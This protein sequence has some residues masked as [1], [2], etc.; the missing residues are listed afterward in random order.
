MGEEGRGEEGI[1]GDLDR[2]ATLRILKSIRAGLIPRGISFSEFIRRAWEI[3]EPN[4]PITWG[5][6]ID[7]LAELLTA[8][9]LGQIKD[10][11]I[12]IPP[13]WMKSTIVSV[14]FPCWEWTFNAGLRY[15]FISHEQ[16]LSTEHSMSRRAILTNPW[17][18]ERWGSR[19]LLC[20]DQNEKT[21]LQN[22][23]R[24]KMIATST[25]G[26][27]TGKGGDRLIFDDY[28]D[29]EMAESDAERN[30]ALRSY[31][32]KFS[33][34]LDSEKTGARIVIE[35]RIHHKD[36]TAKL[37]EEGGWH[38]VVIP[39]DTLAGE[40]RTYQFPLSKRVVEI[41][42]SSPVW[43][44]REPSEIIA[45]K[46]RRMGSRTHDAQ[47]RQRPSSEEG[48]ILK[49][50]NWRFYDEIP[51][52][53]DPKSGKKVLTNFAEL[54]QSWDA[55]FKDEITSDFVVGQVWG[56]IGADRYLLD[57]VRDRM[58]FPATLSAII[59]LTQKHPR[60]S[61]KLIEDK[62]NGPA[63]IA[64]LK[65]TIPGLIPVEPMG[66]KIVRTR[67]VE[68]IQESGNIWLPSPRIAPWVEELIEECAAF[69]NGKHD[70]QVDALTQANNFFTG[71]SGPLFS[72]G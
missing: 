22:T 44:E 45:T 72:V 43:P 56:R 33:T 59:S 23:A 3:T 2:A 31:E 15:L 50:Q 65:R 69:P 7:Y 27:A 5:W 32:K 47:C 67:A 62:A 61:R 1:E 4:K 28:I 46:R 37:I 38:H 36:F 71:N 49:R 39:S 40:R 25:H 30:A 60:A 18:Q 11:L 35:Q 51:H 6:P 63:I 55:T 16:S 24:G 34:R 12:N 66:S 48:A 9:S 58:N 21:F 13:R 29:P 57:Q 70:D 54:I 14:D 52:H 17:Y 42:E 8:V 53:L 41:P 26:R 19:V 68:P 64:M 20:S 10:L